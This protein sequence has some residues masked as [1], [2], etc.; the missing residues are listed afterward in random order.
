MA[1]IRAQQAAEYL[2]ISKSY[3]DKARIYGGGPNF[4]KVGAAVIYSTK[5][6]DIWLNDKREPVGANDNRSKRGLAA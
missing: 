1:N 4:I 2:G 3:L 5:D 6:L